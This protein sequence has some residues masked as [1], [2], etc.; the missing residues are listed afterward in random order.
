MTT[1][2]PSP[3]PAGAVLPS[4]S[5]PL[6]AH[7]HAEGTQFSLWAPRASRVELVLVGANQGATYVSLQPAADGVWTRTVP[8]V[9]SGQRYAYRVHGPWAPDRGMRFQPARLLVDPYARA[10][11]ESHRPE[12]Q[13]A[14]PHRTKPHRAGGTG[15]LGVVVAPSAAPLPLPAPVPLSESVLYELHVKGFTAQH[16][17]VPEQ[18]R[19]TYAGLG[20]PSVTKYLTG[21]G[22]TA[23]ELLPVQHF[24]SERILA[25]RGRVNYWG[26]NTLGYF[27]PH[28][29]YGSGKSLG[30]QVGE[31]QEMVSALHAA[32]LE[33]ILDVVYNHTAEAGRNGPTWSFRGID[34]AG[35]YRL[36][37]DLRTDY[38]TTGCGNSVD[39]SHP[40]V[41]AMIMDSLRYWVTEM[42][43]DGFRFD[44]ATTLLRDGK[45]H[46]DRNHP[47]L[48]AVAQDPLL[49]RVKLIAEPWDLG[50]H[51]YQLGAF[52]PGWSEWND[53]FRNFVRD[54]W[55]G[56]TH[57][58]GG[59]A[60]RLAGSPDVFD[61]TGRPVTASINFVTAHDGF[62]LRDLVSYG[63]KHNE[64]NGEHNRD[65]TDD[66]R[67]DNGGVEGET[68]DRT[69]LAWRHRQ[70]QNLMATLLIANGVPMIT[71]GDE[72]GRTQ[73][74]NN[75]AYCQDSPLSW[76]E[77]DDDRSWLDLTDLTARLLALRASHPVLRRTRFRHG[78]AILDPGGELTGRKNLAWFSGRQEMQ[79]EDWRDPRRRTLGMYLADDDPA[80]ETDDAF[81]VW[82][83]SGADPVEV[84]LPD[85]A[86]ATTYTV[87]A[88]TASPG[89]L[90]EDKIP[91]GSVLRLP[92]RTV[93]VLQV[94]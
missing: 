92:G 43:V 46:V 90:P 37:D 44:L 93:A 28:A 4:T 75:N 1:S 69:V 63:R 10:I 45:H 73:Q 74:G 17:D 33:V 32:G 51:G 11:T 7:L 38:D 25:A 94:D 12:P 14:K 91:A 81:L 82:F 88:G 53:Q 30:Q 68:D 58:V 6:G 70:A 67:S 26:Y 60:P 8:G 54:F 78:E 84:V 62:T 41:L 23:V 19:G 39:T 20:H 9:G 2:A 47:F 16:P 36:S 5:P 61:R 71:A 77:W 64:A 80:R 86:W 34:H 56:H 89:E 49:S 59:L 22:V 87:V 48:T 31:F 66:N 50:P 42:G 57:G 85:G 55:R 13:G 35:Y 76:V 79:T 27:A 40:V 24:V 18:L 21:L 83:H 3:L 65:G 72:R 29:A 52:G 15:P